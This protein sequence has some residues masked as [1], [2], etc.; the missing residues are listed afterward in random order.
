[1]PQ[2]VKANKKINQ[3][4]FTTDIYTYDLSVSWSQACLDDFKCC[5]KRIYKEV[6][7]HG[8]DLVRAKT[9]PL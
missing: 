7:P 5:F 2:M 9:S 6:L 4:W 1:M 3:I 8:L